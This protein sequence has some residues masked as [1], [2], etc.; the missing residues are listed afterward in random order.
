L[1][2]RAQDEDIDLASLEHMPSI[3]R[4]MTPFPY[5]VETTTSLGEAEAL[6]TE[7]GVHQVPVHAAGQLIGV[8]TRGDV[9]RRRTAARS[10]ESWR[11]VPV[12]EI[13]HGDPFV[14][15]LGHPLDEV[16]SELAARRIGSALVT[17][18]GRL[19]GVFSVTDA[20]RLLAGILRARFSHDDE[21]A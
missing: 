6:M 20:C 12:S 2:V 13:C 15:E 18:H 1:V 3:A 16:L 14:V 5:S 19:A 4:V 17:R 7:H 8:V 9:E 21:V 11:D 10:D